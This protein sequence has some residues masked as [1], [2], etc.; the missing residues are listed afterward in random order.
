MTLQQLKQGIFAALVLAFITSIP[1]FYL[2]YE[3]GFSWNGGYANIDMDEFGY[4]AY[5]NALIDGRP[6]RNDPYTGRDNG[7]VET[8]TSIQFVPGYAL[9]MPARLF[10]LS[11]STIFILLLPLATIAAALAVF[12][13]LVE[14]TGNV[15]LAAIGSLG[16][17]CLGTA[18]GVNPLNLF[19]GTQNYDVFPFLRRYVPA[20]PLPVF[21]LM[22]L[23]VWRSLTKHVLWAL[24]AALCF[25]LLVYSYF[26]LW[27]A[28]AAWLCTI[29]LLW[30]VCRWADRKK[31]WKISAIL[32]SAGAVSLLPYVWMLMH[33][34]ASLDQRQVLEKTRLP[35]LFRGPEI[36]GTLILVALVY[37]A[38]KGILSLRDPKTLFMIS[39]V[40]MPLIVFNQQILTGRSL[41]PFHYEYF[42]A[43]YSVV[44]A[45]FVALATWRKMPQRLPRLLA[46]GSVVIGLL[47]GLRITQ[48]SIYNS[49]RFDEGR[50]VALDLKQSAQS[51]VAFGSNSLLMSTFPTTT[52]NPVLWAGHLAPF[53]SLEPA[54]LRRRLHQWA[55]YRGLSEKDFSSMLRVSFA[56][57]IQ[58]FGGERADP[59]LSSHPRPITDEEI[60]QAAREYRSLADSFDEQ[61]ARDPV[62]SYAIV[63]TS[64]DLTN[65][66]H[67]YERD[68]GRRFG[69]LILYRV[70]LRSPTQ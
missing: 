31:V 24:L 3:R 48:I 60:S 26:F 34:I 46:L 7:Q 22:C 5:L 66:D 57:R 27:T 18:A 2:I 11:A 9:A 43:N 16:V 59:A 25:V 39:F 33:R 20:F 35:D 70:K 45:A 49:L 52:A 30:L 19:S 36:Y 40:M 67:W 12:A 62:L 51:G 50:A 32:F 65:L 23:F 28:A 68:E 38:R 56:E 58:I 29:L 17:F 53:S 1:Q 47:I 41:Q 64:D 14:L 10:H 61:T 54:T 42:I 44:L 4:S 6:R 8:F 63:Y 21:F 15:Q 13:L 37:Q 55:Y 69:E